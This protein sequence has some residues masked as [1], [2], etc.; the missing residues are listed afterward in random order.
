MQ[1]KLY[2]FFT[3]RKPNDGSAHNLSGMFKGACMYVCMYV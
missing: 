3:K 1:N 2:D